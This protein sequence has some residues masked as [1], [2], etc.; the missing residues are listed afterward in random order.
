V[1]K[2]EDRAPVTLAQEAVIASEAP[3]KLG[4]FLHERLGLFVVVMQMHF[5]VGNTEAHNLRDAAEDLGPVF[6]LRVEKRVLEALT[7]R[8]PGSIFSDP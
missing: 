1:D 3:A 6:L 8:I 7:F 5:H 4:N 2:P